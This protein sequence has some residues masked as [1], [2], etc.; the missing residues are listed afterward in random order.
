MPQFRVLDLPGRDQF[1]L[2]VTGEG[3]LGRD[4]GAD[5]KLEHPTVSRKHAKL[6][7]NGDKLVLVD[8]SSANGT[9]VNGIKIEGP[10][11]LKE[12]DAVQFGK[13]ST[14]YFSA[15]APTAMAPRTAKPASEA[16][17]LEPNGFET[18]DTTQPPT[19]SVPLERFENLLAA[20]LE[21]LAKPKSLM[22][23]SQDVGQVFAGLIPSLKQVGLLDP[24]GKLIG[25]IRGGRML[26]PQFYQA[27]SGAVGAH[28]GT[29]VLEGPVLAGLFSQLN[30]RGQIPTNIVCLPLES[31][32]LPDVVLYLEADAPFFRGDFADTIRL[33]AKLLGPL[34]DRAPDDYRYNLSGD[35][36]RLAERVQKKMLAGIPNTLD[37]LSIATQSVPHYAIGGDFIVAST[38]GKKEHAFLLGDVS[39][40]GVSASL[41]ASQIVCA[42]RIL[43]KEC[44]GPGEFLVALNE[45]IE[46]NLEPG[47]FAT[48]AVVFINAEK[49]ACRLALAGHNPP[50]IRTKAGKVLEFGF[51]PGA[52]LGSVSKLEIREQ[53]MMLAV[54]DSIILNSDGLEEAE[55]PVSN[56]N[57]VSKLS[58][59][60]TELFGNERRN[61]VISR[62]PGA[63]NIAIALREAVFSFCDGERSSDDLSVLVIERLS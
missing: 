62:T 9:R 5:Y 25:G 33:G 23:R 41:V 48:A 20:L 42:A 29:L 63:Q 6:H 16:T 1:D 26:N 2:K 56:K 43:L 51:D 46:P 34:L 45:A 10:T 60:T 55:K 40:K 53:R 38:V 22:L 44:K 30:F 24:C 13:V 27:I 11:T 17:A 57:F 39:G 52:P 37:G 32:T 8:L 58:T 36:F 19:P 31:S 14:L 4:D 50:V 49:G 18:A 12:G 7:I 21:I 35:D 47:V 3:V 59:G 54:G 61:E 28:N 15:N